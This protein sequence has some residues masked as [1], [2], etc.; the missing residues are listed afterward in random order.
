MLS[1]PSNKEQNHLSHRVR[2]RLNK[3]LDLKVYREAHNNL[4]LVEGS[5]KL[6]P[7]G[8]SHNPKLVGGN[9]KPRLA[10][11]NLNPKQDAVNNQ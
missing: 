1:L 2:P 10:G 6:R 4:K 11:G 7:V 3:V 9:H 8:D 5:H